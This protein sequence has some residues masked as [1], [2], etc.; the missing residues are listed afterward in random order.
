MFHIPP[1]WLLQEIFVDPNARTPVNYGPTGV[2]NIDLLKLWANGVAKDRR[3][4]L[5]WSWSVV[6]CYRVG[7]H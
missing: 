6:L 7:F 4:S 3:V 1:H 2:I 5:R